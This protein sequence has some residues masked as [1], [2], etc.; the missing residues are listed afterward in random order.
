MQLPTSQ[1]ELVYVDFHHVE[2]ILVGSLA[3]S[4]KDPT[5]SLD[6]NVETGPTARRRDVD[7]EPQHSDEARPVDQLVAFEK[8]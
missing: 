2:L 1:Q 8:R 3:T 6:R 4:S 5:H 7:Q